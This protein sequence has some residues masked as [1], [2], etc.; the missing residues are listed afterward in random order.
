MIC[1]NEIFDKIGEGSVDVDYKAIKNKLKRLIALK[2]V[3]L[4]LNR[5]EKAK[6]TSIRKHLLLIYLNIITSA[7]S[8]KSK[9]LLLFC[10]QIYVL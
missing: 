7:K 6:D 4:I 1:Y 10:L 8:T 9:R 2:L 3:P 5:D